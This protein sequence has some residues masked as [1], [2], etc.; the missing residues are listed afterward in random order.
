M[1]NTKKKK[2]ISQNI[3]RE[4]T[5]WKDVGIDGNETDLTEMRRGY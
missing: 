5:T 3:L 4:E 1:R 2:K